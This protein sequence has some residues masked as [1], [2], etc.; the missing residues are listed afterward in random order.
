M[1]KFNALNVCLDFDPSL[2]SHNHDFVGYIIQKY[3]RK[4]VKGTILTRV[5]VE[6]WY[7]SALAQYPDDRFTYLLA[8]VSL[9]GE[10]RG[11]TEVE[12]DSVETQ[13]GGVAAKRNSEAN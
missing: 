1:L 8:S 11:Q 2:D 6:H 4:V 9:I 3:P 7:K 12:D 5:S 10:V 13:Y